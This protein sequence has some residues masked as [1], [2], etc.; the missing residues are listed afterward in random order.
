L[1]KARHDVVA[2]WRRGITGVL[3][4]G[5]MD[6]ICR[7]LARAWL[8]E[9]VEKDDDYTRLH[10]TVRRHIYSHTPM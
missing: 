2:L 9:G 5:A 6:C 3:P 4:Q 8:P 10:F 7:K 1:G